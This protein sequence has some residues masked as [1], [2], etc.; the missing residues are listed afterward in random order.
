MSET[1]HP[2]L[3]LATPESFSLSEFPD[4]LERVLDA[5]PVACLRLDLASRDEDVWPRSADVVR[6][7]AHARE[8]ALVI[9]DH[10]LLA[11]RLGLDGVHLTD[12]HKSIREARKVLGP[13]AIV[14][15]FC[16]T[17]RHDG[18]T[19]GEAGADY[20]SFGPI[21]ATALG[22]GRQADMDLFAWWSEMIEIPVVAEGAIDHEAVGE[23][24]PIADFVCLG[25]KSGTP[26]ILPGR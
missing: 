12:A 16:G 19:A 20:V 10:T 18:M 23:L 15:S 1:D 26:R 11:E 6:E 22:D 14:G 3:Y 21:G 5:A 2:Q 8:I 4:V 25:R 17:S 24:A 7:I 13:D 9:R